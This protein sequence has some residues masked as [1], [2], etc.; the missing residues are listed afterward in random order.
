MKAP[1]KTS[2][3]GYEPAPAGAFMARV[4][5]LID[6]GT[7]EKTYKGIVSEARLV[8]VFFEL[9]GE[10]RKY[11]DDKGVEQEAPILVSLWSKTLSMAEKAWLR[12]VTDATLNTGSL[13]DDT[14]STVELKDMLGKPC[15]VTIEHEVGKD[16]KTYA[17]IKNISQLPKGAL[18]APMLSETSYFSFDDSTTADLAKLS[19]RMQEHIKKAAEYQAFANGNTQDIQFP[20]PE[21]DIDPNDIPFN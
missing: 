12:K 20:G 1:V 17:N 9:I 5:G 13:D 6:M 18:V 4:Q 8:T 15:L 21:H 10:T 3:G 16:G 11:T 7:Q 14:A 19:E 2:G